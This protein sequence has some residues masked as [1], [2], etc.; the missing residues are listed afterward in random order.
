MMKSAVIADFF[1]RAMPIFLTL[2]VGKA[3]GHD[4][5]IS[6][7]LVASNAYSSI[8]HH[9]YIEDPAYYIR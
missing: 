1:C 8:G 9:H 4:V 7:V 2:T 6:Y 3:A 5:T